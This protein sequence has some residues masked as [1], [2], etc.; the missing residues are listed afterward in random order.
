MQLVRNL[1]TQLIPKEA[2]FWLYKLRHQQ[3]MEDLKHTVFP[4]PKGDFS[5]RRYYANKCVFVHITKAAGTSLALSLFGE[6]PYHYTAQDYRVIYG[7][8]DYNNFFKFT[9]VRNPWDRLYSAYSYLKGGGWNEQ[10]AQWSQDNLGD[11]HSFD[12]FVINWLSHERLSAHIHLWPQSNFICNAWE[13]PIIDYLGY[14][15]TI[16]QDFNIIAARLNLNKTA[17]KHTNASQR[18]GYTTV[19][20]AAAKQKVAELYKTDIVNFG[21]QFDSLNRMRIEGGKFVRAQ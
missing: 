19:Y 13:K 18:E 14:F 3:E 10:D 16:E 11:I 17:L 21:Y 2:R 9:F 7:R 15:E 4:S 8:R 20:S 1:Y 6:L 12:D 5:L